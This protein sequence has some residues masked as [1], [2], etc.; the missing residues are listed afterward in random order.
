MMGGAYFEKH[1]GNPDNVNEEEMIQ[2]AL[3]TV[4]QHLGFDEEPIRVSLTLH[5]V[6]RKSKTHVLITLIR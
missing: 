3:A 4:A 2:T 1:F 6:E 5:K